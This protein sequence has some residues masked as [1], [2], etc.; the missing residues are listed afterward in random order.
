MPRTRQRALQCAADLAG[1]EN[2]DLLAHDGSK[3]GWR[4]HY[5]AA[6]KQVQSDQGV[7]DTFASFDTLTRQLGRGQFSTTTLLTYMTG[8]RSV[9]LADVRVDRLRVRAERG[10]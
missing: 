8:V 1:T 7:G 3:S 4:S 6:T 10:L 5:I 9:K 2:V